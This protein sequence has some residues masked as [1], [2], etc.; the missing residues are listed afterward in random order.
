MEKLGWTDKE[1]YAMAKKK[2]GMQFPTLNQPEVTKVVSALKEEW[3]Q[4]GDCMAFLNAAKKKAMLYP[5]ISKIYA[6]DEGLKVVEGAEEQVKAPPM[7]TAQIEQL[8]AQMSEYKLVSRNLLVAPAIQMAAAGIPVKGAIPPHVQQQLEPAGSETLNESQKDNRDVTVPSLKPDT[9]PQGLDPLVLLKQREKMIQTKMAARLE[10]LKELPSNLPSNVMRKAMIEMKSLQL[11]D[12]QRKL[13]QE[14]VSKIRRDTTLDTTLGRASYRRGKKQALR[15]ARMTERLERQQRLEQEKRRRAK[16]QEYLNSILNHAKEF[17][18]FHRNI[19]SKTSKIAKGVTQYH[20][21]REKEQK[22]KEEQMEKE[23]LKRLMAEDEEGYRK[24]LDKEKDKRLAYLLDQTDEYISGLTKLVDKHKQLESSRL[25][26][27]DLEETAKEG[28]EGAQ[29]TAANSSDDETT[30]ATATT[31]ENEVEVEGDEKGQVKNYVMDAHAIKEE[32]TKQPDMLVNGTLKPYQLKGLEWLVSLYNNNLNGI[33]ADEMGLGKTIQSISL[34]TYLMEKKRMM[35]PYLI[36]VP[37]STLSNWVLEFS[38]WAP[39]CITV[40]YKGQPYE[41]K[42]IQGTMKGGKFNVCLTTYEYIIKDRPYLSRFNWRY[43]IIDEGHRMKNHH[44]KLTVCLSQYYNAPYRLLLTGT[45][46]QNNIPELWSLLNFLLPS[47]FHSVTNFEAWFNAPFANTNEKVS[48]TEEETILIIRRLHRVLS[49][50]L[51]R[52]LKKQ[53]ETQLP[54]KT[55]YVIKCD[56]SSLQRALYRHM[57]R[58]GVLLIDDDDDRKKKKAKTLMNI[59]VQLRKIVNHPFLYEEVEQAL[60]KH[61]QIY[62]GQINGPDLYR[63]SGKF[64]LLDRILPKMKASKHKVLMFCQM[65]QCMTIIEDYFNWRGYK[66]MRLDGGTKSEDR[67]D[68]LKLFNAPDSEYFIF[69]LSTRAGGLGLNLQS[70]DTVVI[71]D[72]DWNPHQDLQAQDRA[73]RIGQKNEV[74]VLRLITSQSV[75]E[76]IQAAAQ[77]K[78]DMDA[79]VIQSGKFDQKSSAEERKKMLESLVRVDDDDEEREE[80]SEIPDDE[81]VNNMIARSEE[82]LALFEKLDKEREENELQFAKDMGLDKPKPRLMQKEE[83]PEVFLKEE[84]EV[85]EIMNEDLTDTH[86]RGFRERKEVAY[87]DGM[88]DQAW[89]N[90]VERGNVDEEVVKRRKRREARIKNA[91]N[92]DETSATEEDSTSRAQSPTGREKSATPSSARSPAGSPS[93]STPGRRGR[94]PKKGKLPGLSPQLAKGLKYLWDSIRKY[95]DEE[96]RLVCDIFLVLPSKK[97]YPD[98]YTIVTNP[99]D[100]KK[101]KEKLDRN[102]YRTLDDMQN[103]I[104]LLFSNARTYNMEGSWVYNDSVTLHKVFNDA[105]KVVEG[106]FGLQANEISSQA[107]TRG[108]GSDDTE[109]GE[110]NADETDESKESSVSSLKESGSHLL[111]IKL[112]R[113]NIESKLDPATTDEPSE[114]EASSKTEDDTATPPSKRRKRS[115]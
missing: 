76:K 38:K 55:E 41:R 44:S 74:R 32:V 101:I 67:G 27:M 68:L 48:L 5:L 57:Q 46:L 92:A 13:R 94:K 6:T 114:T 78:L 97:V 99:I 52:R 11:F 73:H 18:E 71:F 35:G 25:K 113:K 20:V 15:E 72:S 24:L 111:R 109:P 17:K 79:K 64:E 59:I 108:N 98:Y 49:P 7:T 34:V 93:G 80:E 50:F 75:E 62:S 110:S 87:N 9:A 82:E 61:M 26:Q 28:E 115:E 45:P 43:M 66:Y 10:E 37:L 85:D 70:A 30:T 88:S 100:M 112:H 22:K 54:D 65:T 33:L 60:C 1:Q 83:L 53:V 69:L 102:S 47:I 84:K 51:L 107:K 106:E 39:S 86:G 16:H 81:Q 40:V 8:K 105:R 96:G 21:N 4:E 90:A 36:I 42:R 19:S 103:D 2:L 89:L 14:I 77:Y 104:E 95:K 31:A 56:M 12:M 58:N 91:S 3:L 63:V 29:D 23:R